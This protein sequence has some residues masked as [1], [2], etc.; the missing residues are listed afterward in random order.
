MSTK[1]PPSGWIQSPD[2]NKPTIYEASINRVSLLPGAIPSNT[3]AEVDYS[4]GSYTVYT[5]PFVLGTIGDRTPLYTRSASG[6]LKVQPGR[7]AE[8]QSL[9]QRGEIQKLDGSI[10]PRV[11]QLNST[12]GTDK[13]RQALANSKL[14][15]SSSNTAQQPD[16]PPG[17]APAQTP[18]QAPPSP[19]AGGASPTTPE[20]PQ[21]GFNISDDTSIQGRTDVKIAGDGLRYPKDIATT[22]QDRIKFQVYDLVPR[23]DS[24]LTPDS[25][26]TDKKF[27][28]GTTFPEPKTTPSKSPIDG[29]VFLPIQPTISDQNGVDWG[30]D[31]LNAIDSALYNISYKLITDTPDYEGTRNTLSGISNN[32]IQ[33]FMQKKG[34]TQRYI[35]G[36]AAGVNNILARTDNVVLNPNM[37]L[38][39]QGPTLRP[40]SFSFKLSPRDNRETIIVRKIIRYFKYYMSVRRENN[41]IF[42][43]SPH[44]FK[45]EYQYKNKDAH[46]GI[47]KIKTCALTNCSVDYTPLG[48]YMTY[49]DG[50]MVS[51]NLTLQF[52]ELT[53]VYQHD[54]DSTN[55][56]SIGY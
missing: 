30:S 43:R 3:V 29:P 51:Y 10:K 35:A 12:F 39:F 44:V 26:N 38:L 49:D 25:I 27:N 54:Y 23:G 5:T 40:F 19:D 21:Y 48:S 50:T 8:F 9:S 24:N 41:G 45:I 55:E 18:E 36:Q 15:K 31:N 1:R 53:P 22:S 11:V 14:Y 33:A 47:N 52:Q 37:E 20:T 46:P 17:P 2:T 13:E 16:K 32:I 42:L 56:S 34:R 7:E 28:I 4:T 6:A